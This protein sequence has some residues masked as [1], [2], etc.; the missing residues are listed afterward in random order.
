M[1]YGDDEYGFCPLGVDDCERKAP[2]WPAA[3]PGANK[4]SNT[5]VGEEKL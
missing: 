3:H 2:E 4:L 5:W 1:C